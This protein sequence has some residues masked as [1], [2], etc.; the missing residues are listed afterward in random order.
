M[1][2]KTSR[3]TAAHIQGTR[4]ARAPRQRPEERRDRSSTLHLATYGQVPRRLHPRQARSPEP[5]RGGQDRRPP[6]A[7]RG[8]LNPRETSSHAFELKLST[9]NLKLVHNVALF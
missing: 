3:R 9:M 1:V 5:Y 8:P 2:R 7:R 6:R 4:G